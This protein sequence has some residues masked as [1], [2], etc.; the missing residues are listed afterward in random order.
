MCFLVSGMFLMG[1]SH[2]TIGTALAE[3]FPASVRYTGA[4]L[5]FTLAGVLGASPAPALATRL[6]RDYGLNYVGYYISFASVITL[7]ALLAV[8]GKMSAK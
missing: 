5:T 2:G 3:I 4:S 8:R 7:M 1:L 6:A